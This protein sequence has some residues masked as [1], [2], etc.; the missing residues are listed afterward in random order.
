MVWVYPKYYLST[1]D[2]TM[3][4]INILLGNPPSI[5]CKSPCL[6]LKTTCLHCKSLYWLDASPVLLIKSW[7]ASCWFAILC[8]TSKFVLAN[9]CIITSV[10]CHRRLASQIPTLVGLNF[11]V[12]VT[13]PFSGF[14]FTHPS[15]CVPH[16][17]SVKST[18]SI[19]FQHWFVQLFQLFGEENNSRSINDPYFPHQIWHRSALHPTW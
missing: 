16:F 5:A 3:Y 15:S 7:L 8:L 19:D 11:N 13:N 2:F 1:S 10:K 4:H 9:S 14:W 6:L 18:M 17:F 12:P